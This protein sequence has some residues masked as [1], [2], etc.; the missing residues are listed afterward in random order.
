[1]LSP[2]LSHLHMSM[3]LPYPDVYPG[4]GLKQPTSPPAWVG[5]RS[6]AP[7]TVLLKEGIKGGEETR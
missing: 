5:S 2:G 7:D 1:M 6:R 3:G 4:L